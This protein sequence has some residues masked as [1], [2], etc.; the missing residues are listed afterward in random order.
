MKSQ[1]AKDE[2]GRFQLALDCY[3]MVQNGWL[4]WCETGR[5]L[6]YDLLPDSSLRSSFRIMLF[7]NNAI[8]EHQF[9]LKV[10]LIGNLKVICKI[11]F[12]IFCR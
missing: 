5:A 4:S 2:R 8:C 10:Y 6:L 1:G 9:S 3:Q 12:L 11:G 7:H